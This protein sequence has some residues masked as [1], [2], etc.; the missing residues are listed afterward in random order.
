MVTPNI[1]HIASHPAY[2]GGATSP[3]IGINLRYSLS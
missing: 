2:R 1:T 3:S